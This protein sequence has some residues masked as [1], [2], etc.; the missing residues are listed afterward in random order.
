MKNQ[1][2]S[3]G[4]GIETE[5]CLVRSD[6]FTPLFH[7]D[8]DFERLLALVEEIDVAD[9]PT[10]G[11][12]IKP[13]HRKAIPYLIEGYYL[14]DEAMKPLEMLV[15]GLEIRTPIADSIEG[16]IA[17]LAV[18]TERLREKVATQN[19]SLCSI[20]HH[21][22]RSKFEAR[23]NYRRN[24]YWQ[25]ALTAMT[26]FGPDFNVSVPDSLQDAVN[27][28]ELNEKI[29]Y[30]LPSVVAL[31][32][33]SPLE[34]GE[35]WQV[36]GQVGKSLRTFQRSLYAPL[37]Y[38]HTEPS[39]RFEFKG[40]EMATDMNDY[41]GYFLCGL[42]MLLD[43]TLTGRASD[44]GR[45][46]R[47]REL[48]VTGLC[49]PEDKERAAKVLASAE[50]IACLFDF[51]ASALKTLWERLE[52]NRTPADDIIKQFTTCGTVEDTMRTLAVQP[53]PRE[54]EFFS[55]SV[56]LAISR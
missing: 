45:I 36:D 6:N 12:N 42:S 50:K 31:S 7:E 37:Y 22:T 35:L 5:H 54:S 46:N 30:Y 16:S 44:E 19:I 18:L 26:T 23:R 49:R 8:L 55:S 32:F 41:K 14:T 48:S 10:D 13:L 20:S 29:N 11:F 21:P 15:K 56:C 47:L 51:D 53:L 24:D 4:F 39:L 40:F 2:S 1:Q 25:W 3:F 17:R 28:D 43:D 9:F 34:N 52:S 27:R 33:A 38:V